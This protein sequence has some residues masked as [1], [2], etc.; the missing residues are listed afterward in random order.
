[1]TQALTA[2]PS[3]RYSDG[4]YRYDIEG[5]PFFVNSTPKGTSFHVLERGVSPMGM[6]HEHGRRGSLSAALRFA[7]T[8]TPSTTADILDRVDATLTTD[9]DRERTAMLRVTG[10]PGTRLWLLPVYQDGRFHGLGEVVTSLGLAVI[11][12]EAMLGSPAS[13][14]TVRYRRADGEE[15]TFGGWS[16]LTLADARSRWWITDG[17]GSLVSGGHRDRERMLS[18]AAREHP[19]SVVQPGTDFIPEA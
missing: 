16:L 6:A 4:G 10:E 8:L 9:R 3:A 7:A 12:I 15:S 19:G 11:G 18:L 13:C 5:G 14:W 2:E 17:A 1:M